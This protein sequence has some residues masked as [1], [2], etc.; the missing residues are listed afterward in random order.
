MTTGREC[1]TAETGDQLGRV[2][3]RETEREQEMGLTIK[4]QF[5]PSGPFSPLGLYL[6]HINDLPKQVGI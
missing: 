4:H 5:H 3:P 6:L 1:L 2:Q